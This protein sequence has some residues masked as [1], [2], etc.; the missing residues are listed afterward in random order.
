MIVDTEIIRTIQ[1]E[2]GNDDANFIVGG[3]AG[4]TP[5]VVR[6]KGGHLM[7]STPVTVEN[8]LAEMFKWK[9]D[10][11]DEDTQTV[12]ERFRHGPRPI[13][14]DIVPDSERIKMESKAA[15]YT[16]INTTITLPGQEVSYDTAGSLSIA[17]S[18]LAN[19]PIPMSEVVQKA[20]EEN[21]AI[22]LLVREFGVHSYDVLAS[23][24]F[25]LTMEGAQILSS[26]DESFVDDEVAPKEDADLVVLY[27]A[28]RSEGDGPTWVKEIFMG[29]PWIPQSEIIASIKRYVDDGI[30]DFVEKNGRHHGARVSAPVDDSDLEGV[31]DSDAGPKE[32]SGEFWKITPDPDP[33]SAP[34][35]DSGPDS[36]EDEDEHVNDVDDDVDAD[37]V[38]G[39]AD[40]D[41]DEGE[42]DIDL[43]DFGYEDA[44]A[45]V[46]RE[47]E[48]IIALLN[49]EK[50][51]RSQREEA[52][53]EVEAASAAAVAALDAVAV[54]ESKL[55]EA[56][57]NATAADELRQEKEDAVAV[58]DEDIA[59][60][61]SEKKR[62]LG[63]F[64]R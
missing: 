60:I 35:D 12:V 18:Y 48:R 5:V 45:A 16:F 55:S 4:G 28:E 41:E 17:N 29:F 49:K 13:I 2:A 26:S 44:V 62:V 1:K 46:E 61:V 34:D 47:R 58:L 59:N 27:R 33:D 50:E 25:I 3:S 6:I 42:G 32:N 39:G 10:L 43:A 19:P 23:G 7:S 36:D 14:N 15:L 31:P 53:S 64:A 24:R 20:R 22:E 51:M 57:A 8:S 11:N 56:K 37:V 54:A 40:S 21:A 38:N 9:F 30:I 63:R 52:A